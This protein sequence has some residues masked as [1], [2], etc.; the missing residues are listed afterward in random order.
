MKDASKIRR[1][2]VPVRAI[3]GG[4]SIVTY[5]MLDGGA[6]NPVIREE[7]VEALGMKSE[8]KESTL[9]TVG[10]TA[11][12]VRRF[13]QL[14]VA[15]L[16]GDVVLN[17]KEALIM[18]ILTTEYDKPPTNEEVKGEAYLEGVTFDELEDKSVNMILPMEFGWCWLGGKVRRSMIDK[19]IALNTEFGWALAGHYQIIRPIG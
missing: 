9:V 4:K 8:E 14:E 15:N 11:Q 12:G 2:I 13:S 7:V 10:V 19:P 17:V 1:L 5:A 3:S 16:G 18:D 6:T